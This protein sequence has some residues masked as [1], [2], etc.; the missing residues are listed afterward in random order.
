MNEKAV[1]TD[2]RELPVDGLKLVGIGRRDRIPATE[3]YSNL[4][5]TNVKYSTYKQPTEKNLKVMERIMTNASMNSE[6]KK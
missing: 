1:E 2:G 3:T 4:D 5:L 6:N